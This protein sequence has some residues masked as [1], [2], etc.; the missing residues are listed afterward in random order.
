MARIEYFAIQIRAN[1]NGGRKSRVKQPVP[2]CR[3]ACTQGGWRPG[4]GAE[5]SDMSDLQQRLEGGKVVILDGATGTELER[6]RA[7]M[8]DAAWDAA[9]LVTHPDMVRK[10][11]VIRS[12]VPR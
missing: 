7:P 8:D 1:W 12:P 11:Q 9:A 4:S 10:V 3:R 6:R 5:R 2:L